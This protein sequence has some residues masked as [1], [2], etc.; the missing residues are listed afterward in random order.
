M[1]GT[2]TDTTDRTIS[3]KSGVT[4]TVAGKVARFGEEGTAGP[5]IALMLVGFNAD[6]QR[7]EPLRAYVHPVASSSLLIP[8]DSNLERRTLSVLMDLQSWLHA[9]KAIDVLIEKP[10][11]DMPTGHDTPPVRP[12][13]LLRVKGKAVVVETMGYDNAEYLASKQRTHPL[14]ERIGP[15]VQHRSGE[16]ADKALKSDA[17]KAIYAIL[18]S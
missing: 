5:F 15:I 16:H 9:D 14:M 6:S 2:A 11:A 3:T 17:A 10:L 12:D 18:R 13:F 7:F 4:L 1:I 8:V